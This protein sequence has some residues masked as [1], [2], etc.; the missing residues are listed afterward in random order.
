MVIMKQSNT[1]KSNTK[2]FIEAY[3]SIDSITEAEAIGKVARLKKEKEIS[4][5]EKIIK[6]TGAKVDQSE[7]TYIASEMCCEWE[8]FENS[9]KS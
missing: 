5:L 3:Q 4:R 2:K 7:F 9:Y 8:D 1:M 6:T